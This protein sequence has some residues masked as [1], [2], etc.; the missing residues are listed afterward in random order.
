MRFPLIYGPGVGANFW[1]LMNWVH[2]GLPLPLGAI[3][4]QR[5][6]SYVG[7]LTE[8][9]ARLAATPSVAGRSSL[10][11]NADALF[12]ELDWKPPLSLDTALQRTLAGNRS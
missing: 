8:A 4:N 9:L 6:L 2:R 11:V 5:S 10:E 3:D 1:Q 12:A 7:H